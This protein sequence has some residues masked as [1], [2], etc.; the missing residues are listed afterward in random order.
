MK[1]TRSFKNLQ[2]AILA[3]I[4]GVLACKQFQVSPPTPTPILMPTLSSTNTITP[5]PT[6]T[7]QPTSTK[8]PRPTAT[9]VPPVSL[10]SSLLTLSELNSVFNKNV[11]QRKGE[12]SDLIPDLST[13]VNGATEKASSSWD[14]TVVFDGDIGI[15]IQIQKWTTKGEATNAIEMYKSAHDVSF[16]KNKA[17]AFITS[18][19]SIEL[20][21]GE[22][23]VDSL[24]IDQF[25]PIIYTAIIRYSNISF[26]IQ[27]VLPNTN[28]GYEDLI[29][30]YVD[31]QIA[32]LQKNGYK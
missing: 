1:N 15:Q 22:I 16:E 19:N 10:S 28:E 6:N 32:K 17:G 31:M 5:D 12:P 24:G 2:M 21:N 26:T 30:G 13:G 29:K 23:I 7:P 4:F 11:W 9:A 27:S 14:G 20:S 18:S 8:R 3:L 25:N